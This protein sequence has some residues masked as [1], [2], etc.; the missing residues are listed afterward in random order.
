MKV[1]TKIFG[2]TGLVVLSSTFTRC[3]MEALPQVTRHPMH[4]R[5][6]SAE[7]FSFEEGVLFS[8]IEAGLSILWE[9]SFRNGEGYK[10]N[11]GFFISGGLLI[12]P[13][14]DNTYK[15]ARLNA[16]PN[17][18]KDNK[19]FVKYKGSFIEVLGIIHT[20]PDIH[21]LRMPSPRNDYQF[22]YLGIHS[23]VMSHFDLFD[24][25]IDA[26]GGETYKRLG[27][28]DSFGLINIPAGKLRLPIVAVL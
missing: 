10:E 14:T 25:Y 6:V 20:H 23:Y 1:T 11:L 13:N 17:L 4:D 28:R 21:S 16:L 22:C 27:P 2:I 9:A 19:L 26:F 15:S 7:F 24:A 3:S 5:F 12:L 8:D 18:V